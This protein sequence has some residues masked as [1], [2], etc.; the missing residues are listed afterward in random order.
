[1]SILNKLFKPKENDSKQSNFDL[2]NFLIENKIP[3]DIEDYENKTYISYLNPMEK[4]TLIF[5]FCD[6]E[7]FFNNEKI[8][9]KEAQKL[10]NNQWKYDKRL[11]KYMESERYSD[12]F[13]I[14]EFFKEIL[15][16][17]GLRE[18]ILP[19][20]D[21]EGV[22]L[23]YNIG[24]DPT[25]SNYVAAI[26]LTDMGIIKILPS[27]MQTNAN[28]AVLTVLM[29]M[30]EKDPYVFSK[31]R[32]KI[33]GDSRFSEIV[34]SYFINMSLVDRLNR[35]KGVE[36][37]LTDMGRSNRIFVLLENDSAIEYISP[38]KQNEAGQLLII[39]FDE[40]NKVEDNESYKSV[41]RILKLST[42]IKDKPNEENLPDIKIESKNNKESRYGRYN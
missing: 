40:E 33:K 20:K 17:D 27:E 42:L 23:Y 2:E 41:S 1:M 12:I 3:Y 28:A 18:K 5:V 31:I 14:S 4:K 39:D 36:A 38:T 34:K 9:E 29:N 15:S 6:N 8:S 7:Y 19:L 26:E 22:R 32:S 16:P 11:M 21:S 13:D 10:I 35:I 24:K 37:H 30:N 25:E